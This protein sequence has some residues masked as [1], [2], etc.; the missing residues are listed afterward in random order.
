MVA[1]FG[2]KLRTVFGARGQ[3]CVGVDPSQSQLEAWSLG[4]DVTGLESFSFG[5]LD[6]VADKVGIVKPQ[7]AFFEQYGS[8]G[9]AVLER[10]CE[11]A[12][13]QGLLVIADAKR[14]DIGS[15]MT[16]Y[17]SAWL[18]DTSPFVTDALT[19]SSYLGPGSTESMVRVALENGKGIFLLA[20]T[21]NPEAIEMQSSQ[22]ANGETIASMVARYAQVHNQSSPAEPTLG[23]IGLVL[24]ANLELEHYGLSEVVLAGTPILAPGFGFQGARLGELKQRFGDLSANVICSVSRSVSGDCSRTA[25]LLIK[26]AVQE[27]NE[28]EVN[29]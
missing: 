19:V 6:A 2:S 7:V 25:S 15:T 26:Q 18:E 8:A 23:S 14:G 20:A 10:F 13:L 3:L 24:G 1:S 4:S 29:V 22:F 11:A 28:G 21:S 9:F 17:A 12:N 5:M 27:L 16:G